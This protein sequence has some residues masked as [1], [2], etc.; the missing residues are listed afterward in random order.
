M[1]EPELLDPAQPLSIFGFDS[2]LEYS[3]QP[4]HIFG[5]LSFRERARN[6]QLPAHP[7]SSAPACRQAGCEVR[8]FALEDSNLSFGDLPNMLCG[9]HSRE[10][11]PVTL[12]VR[13]DPFHRNFEFLGNGSYQVA[14]C[15]AD[16][17]SACF[18]IPFHVYLGMLSRSHHGAQ[19]PNR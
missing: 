15:S 12:C 5:S 7:D 4:V 6:S 17:P 13:F 8:N 19:H 11:N 16:F 14:V 3:A 9:P 1:T 18:F 2:R 10:S